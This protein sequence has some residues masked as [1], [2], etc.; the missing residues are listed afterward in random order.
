MGAKAKSWGSGERGGKRGSASGKNGENEKGG[1]GERGES[2]R[3]IEESIK[4][5]NNNKLLDYLV[6]KN[7]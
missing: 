6:L 3:S 7:L 1:G 4:Y 2:K 5:Y